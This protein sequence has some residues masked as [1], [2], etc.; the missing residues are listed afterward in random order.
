[1][2]PATLAACLALA[3]IPATASAQTIAEDASSQIG[4]L[5]S[6]APDSFV[7]G[8]AP[9]RSRER[10]VNTR[11]GLLTGHGDVGDVD[12]PSTGVHASLGYRL[13]EATFMAEYGYLKLGDSDGEVMSRDG[14]M[15]RAGAALRWRIADVA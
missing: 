9:A 14:R 1:M 8:P 7:A 2:R 12:G 4:S 5:A 6:G 10:R 3:S 11:I 15:S 13:G